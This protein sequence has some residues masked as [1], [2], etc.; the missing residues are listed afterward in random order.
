MNEEEFQTAFEQLAEQVQSLNLRVLELEQVSRKNQELANLAFDVA[1]AS[2]SGA[3]EAWAKGVM[4]PSN[5]VDIVS[6]LVNGYLRQIDRYFGDYAS[7]PHETMNKTFT[8]D[9][10]NPRYCWD[11]ATLWI[12]TALEQYANNL[13]THP[14]GEDEPLIP[15][16]LLL[17]QKRLAKYLPRIEQWEQEWK[18]WLEKRAESKRRYFQ[19]MKGENIDSAR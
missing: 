13:P 12:E 1:L 16:E 17:I 15:I 5:S 2:P 19:R 8:N 11:Q 9:D 4:N 18:Q 14:V 10:T 6:A 3:V 7:D